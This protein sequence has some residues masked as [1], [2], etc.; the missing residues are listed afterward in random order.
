M[1]HLM[2]FVCNIS[3]IPYSSWS[4]SFSSLPYLVRFAFLVFIQLKIASII[5]V[6][7]CVFG[8]LFLAHRYRPLSISIPFHFNHS[9]GAIKHFVQYLHKRFSIRM[10]EQRH[11]SAHFLSIIRSFNMYTHTH[12]I[13]SIVYTL[14]F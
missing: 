9:S 4:I 2:I 7:V 10:S 3:F 5:V 14:K 6:C 8:S 13:C 12:T 1:H 11:P